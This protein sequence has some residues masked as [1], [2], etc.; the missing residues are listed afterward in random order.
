MVQGNFTWLSYKFLSKCPVKDETD[1]LDQN[2]EYVESLC[3]QVEQ[4][5]NFPGDCGEVSQF[6]L[7]QNLARNVVIT[8]NP[9]QDCSVG[10][11]A[12]FCPAE[13]RED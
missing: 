7:G 13:S 1:C 10:A 5:K 9:I 8:F 2:L 6:C 12:S 4:V 11:V 3:H